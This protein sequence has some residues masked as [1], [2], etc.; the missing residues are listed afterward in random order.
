MKS[1]EEISK[2]RSLYKEGMTVTAIAKETRSCTKTVS[3][4]LDKEDFNIPPPKPARDRERITDGYAGTIKAWLEA[5]K[6]APRKQRHTYVRIFE[7]LRDEEGFTGSS[8]AVYRLAKKLKEQ[9]HMEEEEGNGYVPL[10]HSPGEGQGDFGKA[11]FVESG[12]EISGSY[13]V[14]SLP[15]SNA[16]FLQLT[17]GQ[18]A[19]CLMES[20]ISIFEYMGGVP[21]EIWFD[22]AP[23]MVVFDRN[24]GRKR[25]MADRFM[26]FTEH[27]RFKPVFM[28]PD[29]GN[30]KG[31]VEKK[32]GT[33]RSHLLVPVPK[34]D[35]LEEENL[36]MLQECTGFFHGKHHYKKGK[37]IDE[38]F[39][40]DKEALLPLPAVRFDPSAYLSVRADKCGLFKLGEVHT[41][42]SA[43]EY[44]R[45]SLRLRVT[46]ST[47]E[48]MNAKNEVVTVHRRLYG[49]K[50]EK[51]ESIDWLPYLSHI[52]HHPN[53][54]RNTGLR[55]MMPKE[56]A[57]FIE[58]LG[59]TDRGKV[60]Q[61]LSGQTKA[62]GFD[63]AC[64]IL[65]EAM[66][67]QGDDVDRILKDYERSCTG[68]H[69]EEAPHAGEDPELAQ[70]AR[71]DL[72]R[73]A[74]LLDGRFA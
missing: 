48:V 17:Y 56:L 18:N 68:K 2:M 70:M 47:V 60:L 21:H 28:Q 1:M 7:R 35:G 4:Y 55:E 36:A 69:D 23:S 13:F 11:M 6:K 43:P 62:M 16:G 54:F 72:D 50:D 34:F 37:L 27:Y 26:A 63:K 24:E 61:A 31:S 5:D 73:F 44:A 51:L 67:R 8:S 14:L 58:A 57:H 40:E 3:K 74:T 59:N 71:D 22:N 49:A 25:R 41:Y 33:L 29:R 30:Q 32:V 45:K 38:L 20:L 42:S 19:E 52:A 66:D 12:K 9:M 39:E 15:Y 53:S 65:Y 46:S 10:I 64:A